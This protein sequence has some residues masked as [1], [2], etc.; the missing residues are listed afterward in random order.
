[1][2]RRKVGPA[3]KTEIDLQIKTLRENESRLKIQIDSQMKLLDSQ[4]RSTEVAQKRIAL[5]KLLKDHEKI[6]AGLQQVC[7]DALMIKVTQESAPRTVF[8]RTGASPGEDT[9]AA[10][11]GTSSERRRQLQEPQILHAI[12]GQDVDDAIREEREREIIK[13]NQDLVLVNEMMRL[14]SDFTFITLI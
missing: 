7:S 10:E 4:P 1:M 6:K 9:T 12:Q 3:E 5:G 8:S 13:M 11:K 14:V 2:R